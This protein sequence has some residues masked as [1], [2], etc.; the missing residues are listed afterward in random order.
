MKRLILDGLGWLRKRRLIAT[1]GAEAQWYDQVYGGEPDSY[2]AHYT[3]SRYL[4]VWEAILDRVPS[5]SSVLEVGCGPGQLAHMLCDRGVQSYVGFDFSASAIELA[6]RRLRNVRFEVDDARTSALFQVVNY[7]TVICTEVL[8]HI[9][10]DLAV[11]ER[12]PAA[13]RVL[14]TVPNFDYET[15]VRHFAD[16]QAVLDRYGDRFEDLKVTQH[17]HAGDSN[18]SQGVFYLMNGRR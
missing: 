18:G 13:K 2:M 16:Q 3:M 6:R 9:V 5:S 15:H 1:G 4:P 12:I 11:I 17:F 7:D 8:E 14:A 10:D